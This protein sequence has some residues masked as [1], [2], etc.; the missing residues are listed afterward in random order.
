MR[1]FQ[2]I[3][4]QDYKHIFNRRILRQAAHWSCNICR[5]NKNVF[6]RLILLLLYLYKF[7]FK[8]DEITYSRATMED[9]QSVIDLRLIFAI[10]FS[11]QQSPDAVLEFKKYNQQYLERSIQNNSFLVFLARHQ[12]EIVGMGG[13]VIREQPGSF[14]NP[15]GKVGY[16]MNMYTFPLFRR[17]G[18]CSAILKLLLEEA[19][20]LGII[21]FELHASEI[22][23]SVYVQ[24]GF[25][26]HHEPTYR[27][28][29][30]GN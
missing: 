1:K 4:C 30:T 10:E 19:G 28:F 11:G 9:L 29:I 22:G 5:H 21:A 23:E 26:K 12:G 2:T 27:K 17:R 24:N 6:A 3:V 7:G 18:I 25:K 13:M 16:I 20:H 14:K 8:L 15:R